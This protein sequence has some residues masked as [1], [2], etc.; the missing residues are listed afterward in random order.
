MIDFAPALGG[1]ARACRDDGVQYAGV[2][3]SSKHRNR[4]ANVLK[5]PSVKR[6]AWAGT[7]FSGL[8]PQRPCDYTSC[9]NGHFKEFIDE[10]HVQNV[11]MYEE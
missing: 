8:A 3:R 10:F 7:S 1:L 4:L 9:L 6:I 11:V 2:C 5:R